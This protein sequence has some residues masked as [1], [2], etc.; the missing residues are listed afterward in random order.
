MHMFN[1]Y[2]FCLYYAYIYNIY[3]LKCFYFVQILCHLNVP[4][5]I[6]CTIFVIFYLPDCFKYIHYVEYIYVFIETFLF[7]LLCVLYKFIFL[8]YLNILCL[9]ILSNIFIYFV[10]FYSGY[11]YFYITFILHIYSG[12]YVYFYTDYIYLYQNMY[13]INT[14]KSV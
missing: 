7:Y 9:F 1:L 12:S 5:C 2:I 8:T 3:L 14:H 6:F 10:Y 13:G 4:V 11:L